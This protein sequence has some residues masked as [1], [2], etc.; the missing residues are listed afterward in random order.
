LDDL[1]VD[2]LVVFV[3]LADSFENV[4]GLIRLA[5]LDEGVSEVSSDVDHIA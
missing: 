5:V 4:E 1:L 2:R 3:G